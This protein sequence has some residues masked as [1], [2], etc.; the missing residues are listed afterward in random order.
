MSLLLV[1]CVTIRWWSELVRKV[2][3]WAA[4][5][6]HRPNI[7][8]KSLYVDSCS[9]VD[10]SRLVFSVKHSLTRASCYLLPEGLKGVM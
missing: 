4:G 6:D 1:S 10:Y 8:S 5:T 9:T 7:D 3:N 2:V